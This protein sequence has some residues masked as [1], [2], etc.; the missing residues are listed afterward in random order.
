MNAKLKVV[1]L[2]LA[3]GNEIVAQWHRHNKP[4]RG[5]RFTLGAEYQGEI[6]GAAIIGR[7]VARM[8]DTST[9]AEVNRLCVSPSAPPNTC[10]FLYGAARRV[11]F[12]MGGKRM[13]T[14]TLT[15]ESGSSLRGAGWTPN[16][17]KPTTRK[18][19]LSR[20]RAHQPVYDQLKIRWE[21]VCEDR[22]EA[23][24]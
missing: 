10:S 24:P 9:T 1:P 6:V 11:W 19:C 18:G 12:T 15:S 7:P 22:K 14:Y 3:R 2:T 8:L 21:T 17:L 13:I 23:Q 4:C 20:D 5:H 16:A